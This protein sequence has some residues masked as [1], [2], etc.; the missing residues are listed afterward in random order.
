MLQSSWHFQERRRNPSIQD[1]QAAR[2]CF[3]TGKDILQ[4][5]GEL[6]GISRGGHEVPDIADQ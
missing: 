2:L 3:K 4:A 5:T 1:F 6:D